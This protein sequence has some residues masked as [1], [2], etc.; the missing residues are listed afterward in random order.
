MATCSRAHAIGLTQPYS[1]PVAQPEEVLTRWRCVRQELHDLRAEE[2]DW[3]QR[4]DVADFET[5]AELGIESFRSEKRRRRLNAENAH[6]RVLLDLYAYEET[7][8]K[9][10]GTCTPAFAMTLGQLE[11]KLADWIVDVITKG[12]GADG[13]LDCQRLLLGWCAQLLTSDVPDST[14]LVYPREFLNAARSVYAFAIAPEV[15]RP[16]VIGRNSP[17]RCLILAFAAFP[18]LEGVTRRALPEY[19]DHEGRTRKSFELGENRYGVGK[20][21]SNLSVALTLLE[22]ENQPND[23]GARL[24]ALREEISRRGASEETRT[25]SGENRD[26]YSILFKHRNSNLHGGAHI[27]HAGLAAL[28]LATLIS[29]GSLRNQ[30]AHVCQVARTASRM[31]AP[32]DP[33]GAWPQ[34][35]FYPVGFTDAFEPERIHCW[36]T[37][38]VTGSSEQSI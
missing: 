11:E 4:M 28:L 16:G 8:D 10:S 35:V 26:L 33:L 18:F 17:D 36:R 22:R 24:S 9:D 5:R 14:G 38:Q 12:I 20:T 15:S 6:L 7:A 31:Q 3:R 2:A 27:A 19:M 1:G 30:F 29:L 21:I 25:V 37:W 13:M 34:W 32:A 23:L